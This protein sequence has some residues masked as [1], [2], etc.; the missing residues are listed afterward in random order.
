[1]KVDGIPSLE[2]DSRRHSQTG[3]TVNTP[4]PAATVDFGLFEA[5]FS[6]KVIGLDSKQDNLRRLHPEV[7]TRNGLVSIHTST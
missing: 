2:S 7:S 3:S 5:A 1:M 4:H 6:L